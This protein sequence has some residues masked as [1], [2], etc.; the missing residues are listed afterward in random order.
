MFDD[1]QNNT[2]MLQMT[3]MGTECSYTVS[4]AF[5]ATVEADPAIFAAELVNGLVLLA[6]EF[7]E[8]AGNTISDDEFWGAV[9]RA[10]NVGNSR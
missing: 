8:R 4:E 2:V 10:K 9:E 5:L 7:N 6:G 1:Y 3:I